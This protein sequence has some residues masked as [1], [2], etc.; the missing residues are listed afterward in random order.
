[1]LKTPFLSLTQHLGHQLP[2][3]YPPNRKL[4]E[5]ASPKKKKNKNKKPPAIRQPQDPKETAQPGH[6]RQ[7]TKV[8]KAS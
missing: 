6:S 4:R 5:S 8:N 2:D 7:K 3:I 1:M